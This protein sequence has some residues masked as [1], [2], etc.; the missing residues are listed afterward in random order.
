MFNAQPTGTVISRRE[1]ERER[2]RVNRDRVTGSD[3]KRARKT[4][5]PAAIRLAFC[6]P[7]C[8]A[9]D[10]VTERWLQRDRHRQTHVLPLMLLCIMLHDRQAAAHR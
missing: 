8:P 2:E 10:C 3:K 6:L 5:N 1:R 4:T 9:P 7:H